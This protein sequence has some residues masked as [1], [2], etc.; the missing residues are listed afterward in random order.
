MT[1]TNKIIYWT[2]T[3]LLASGMLAGGLEQVFHT[4]R[5]ADLFA[6]LGYPLYFSYILGV[7]QILGVIAILVPEFS[8]LKEWAYAGLFF[9]YTGAAASHFLVGDPFGIWLGP[10]IVALITITSWKLRP[11]SRKLQPLKIEPGEYKRSKA[12]CYWITTGLVAFI[13][14]SGGLWLMSSQFKLMVDQNPFLG[15]PAYF[16]QILGFCKLLGGIVI[17]MPRFP[18]AKEWA[19]AGIVFN[20]TGASAVRAFIGASTAHIIVPL[21]ICSIAIAS[22]MLRPESR[23]LNPT[24]IVNINSKDEAKQKL[25]N[26]VGIE[27]EA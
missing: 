7:W 25:G 18:L 21:V 12:I 6:H 23:K 20:M 11:D 5:I 13:L 24:R 14:I 27:R 19:Y 3:I 22:W 15:F 9:T 26:N 17:L 1:K 16:W 2:S 10:L 8:L 4:R